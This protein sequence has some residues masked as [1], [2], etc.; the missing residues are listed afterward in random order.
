MKNP[1]SDAMRLVSAAARSFESRWTLRSLLSVDPELHGKLLAQQAL[2]HE[3]L[4]TGASDEVSEQTSAMCR[5]WRA[6][7]ERMEKADAPDDA[8]LLGV[9]PKT[10]LRVAIG[11]QTAA[12]DRVREVHGEKVVWM[13]PGEVATLLAG[14]QAIAT[15]KQAFPGAELIDLYP[16]EPECA[17]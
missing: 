16:T 11:D 17:A 2:W 9:C 3:A 15:V 7:T 6:V 13:T 1:V 14:T 8:Y 12:M 5:G 4:V 10:G